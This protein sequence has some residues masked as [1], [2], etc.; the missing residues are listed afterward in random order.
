MVE[1]ND[2]YKRKTFVFE[3][4]N[5]LVPGA[6]VNPGVPALLNG[7]PDG[8]PLNRM[9]FAQWLV[10]EDNPLTARTIVNRLWE[11]LFGQGIV[12]TIEDFGTQ[13]EAPSHPELLDYLAV[14]FSK[15]YHW[16]M[17]KILRELVLSSTYKRDSRI[18]NDQDA[19]NKWLS[20]GPRIRLTAE[21]LRDQA[22][23]VSGLLS[24]KMYG[25]SV[26]PYQPD[27]VWQSVYSS[28]RWETSSG[29]DK[30]RRAVYTFMK[31]TSPYPSAV[32]FDASSREVCVVQRVRTNT[33]LQALVTLNDPVFMEAAT[34]LA[35]QSE[36]EKSTV[37]QIAGMYKR[38][39][40]R[41]IS[42]D[43]LEALVNL[44]GEAFETY[45]N[46]PEAAQKIS[47]CKSS[48]PRRAAK[49]VVALAILNL[50]EFLMKE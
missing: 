12:T 50:D 29:E 48:D 32:M 43:K 45:R 46:D 31:R 27:R 47:A 1:N 40:F 7:I 15:E 16:S 38:A 4:G 49:N 37:R 35:A 10:A 26:M 19:S 25:P 36:S 11:Q 30:N 28:E 8:A 17:K 39:M 24:S 6:E 2:E 41:D 42:P 5:R 14:R 44:Y 23:S 33:P 20:R 34:E 9:G 21:Q 13:G 3:R 18:V 22:L